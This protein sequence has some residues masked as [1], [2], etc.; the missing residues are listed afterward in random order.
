MSGIFSFFFLSPTPT[1]WRSLLRAAQL[2]E[3][4]PQHSAP[5]HAPRSALLLKGHKDSQLLANA[6]SPCRWQQYQDTLPLLCTLF[7]LQSTEWLD[8]NWWWR[9]GRE[10]DLIF[11]DMKPVLSWALL[12]LL[13]QP[14]FSSCGIWGTRCW[15]V[16]LLM[17]PS[18]SRK[19]LF[20]SSVGRTIRIFCSNDI[21]SSLF[22]LY[23]TGRVMMKE[24]NDMG[25][26]CCTGTQRK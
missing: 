23:P 22:L 3:T 12:I 8:L 14:E 21:T 13:A 16:S 6:L 10:G 18:N 11:L 15:T 4:R 2:L 9:W 26:G 1:R 17:S 25:S 7:I 20:S 5:A 24:T 19:W